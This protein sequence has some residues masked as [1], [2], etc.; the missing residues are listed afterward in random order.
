MDSSYWLSL[1]LFLGVNFPYTVLHE[2]NDGYWGHV[3]RVP[4]GYAET[5]P[6][7][8][9]PSNACRSTKELV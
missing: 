3:F 6:C 9:G 7:F 8:L 5:F 4:S 1:S 2:I